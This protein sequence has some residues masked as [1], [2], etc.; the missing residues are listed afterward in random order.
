MSI[1]L[2]S[3]FVP[4]RLKLTNTCFALEKRLMFTSVIK[5]DVLEQDQCFW[6]FNTV[7][8][9]LSFKGILFE[10]RHLRRDPLNKGLQKS[11]KVHVK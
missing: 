3:T 9:L 5:Q 7:R 1:Y 8:L 6:W 10:H 4:Y 2:E 11:F